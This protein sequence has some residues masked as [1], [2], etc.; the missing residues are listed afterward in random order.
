MINTFSF[1]PSGSLPE[2]ARSNEDG[3]GEIGQVQQHVLE[4][5]T[6]ELHARRTD[7][8]QHQPDGGQRHQDRRDTEQSGQ[9]QA[10]GAQDLDCS[11]LC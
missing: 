2:A 10:N 4:L 3:Q 1:D 7:H 11:A 5:V 6:A 9:D 8:D